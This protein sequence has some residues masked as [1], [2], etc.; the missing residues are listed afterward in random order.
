MPSF[1]KIK[2]IKIYEGFYFE[3]YLYLLNEESVKKILSYRFRIDQVRS[4][5]SE[6]LKHYYVA[7]ILNIRPE[8][9]SI[10]NSEL[11]KPTLSCREGV[12]SR[13]RLNDEDDNENGL[14][15]NLDGNGNKLIYDLSVSHSGEY[16]VLAVA[17]MPVGIDIEVVDANIDVAGIGEM[18]FSTSENILINNDTK[19]FFLLW[20]KKESL[21]KAYGTG[22]INDYYNKTNLNLEFVEQQKGYTIHSQVFAGKYYLSICFCY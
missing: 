4:F 21:F 20:T 7:S 16:V 19:S 15:C 22:F 6:L 14:S 8:D 17:D 13:L 5:T 1:I 18:V 2:A 12:D 11:G 9:I 3:D 10:I